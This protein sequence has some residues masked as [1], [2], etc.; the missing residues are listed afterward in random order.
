M[1]AKR[2]GSHTHSC[3]PHSL[4]T[5]WVNSKGKPSLVGYQ[6]QI[7]ISATE[8]QQQVTAA[9]TH[10]DSPAMQMTNAAQSLLFVMTFAVTR[11][12]QQLLQ[13]GVLQSGVSA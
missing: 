7:S 10:K 2:M 8:Q 13:P 4:A 6:Q 5:V 12:R 1:V 9:A 3:C 11:L